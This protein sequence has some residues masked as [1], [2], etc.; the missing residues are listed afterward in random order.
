MFKIGHRGALGYAPENTLSSFKKALDLNVD[1]IEL[2]VHL[3]KSG[4]LVVI[5]DKKINRNTNKT[6]AVN[7]KKLEE[8][9]KLDVGNGEKI[10]TLEEA[11][12]FINKKTIVNIELKGENTGK[13]TAKIINDYID[14]KNWESD[15]FLVSSALRNEIQIFSRKA[16]NIKIGL[17]VNCTFIGKIGC[18]LKIPFGYLKFAKKIGAYSIHFSKRL[19][20]KKYIKQSQREGFKIFVWTIN[21]KKNIELMKKNEV[22]GILSDYP[23]RLF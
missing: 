9:K 15:D 18:I 1:M 16:P 3:C 4:E 2:D 7:E 12:I 21:N 20:R 8:L 10:P 11:L 6:G 23:D 17:V 19:I 14:N 5:H 22:D 13:P